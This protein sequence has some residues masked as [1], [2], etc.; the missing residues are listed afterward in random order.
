MSL[1]TVSKTLALDCGFQAPT[2]VIGST[3]RALV[4]VISF[5]NEVGQEIARRADWGKMALDV[6]VTGTGTSAP[7]TIGSN[8][9]KASEGAAAFTSTGGTIRRL[10]RAEWPSTNSQGTPRY[11]MLEGNEIQFWPYL[12]NA[13][14]ATVR[15][16]VTGWTSAGGNTFASDAETTLFPEELLSLGLIAKWRRQKGMAYQDQEAAFEAAMQQHAAFDN[17]GRG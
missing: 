9:L 1:L 3:D 13:A 12:A 4:E 15:I 11:F 5:A 8:V 16:Q 14:T 17:A 7:I 2:N 10:S 6:T